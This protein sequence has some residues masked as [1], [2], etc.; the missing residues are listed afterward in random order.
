ATGATGATGPALYT[1]NFV[2]GN[3]TNFGNA[4]YIMTGSGLTPIATQP[5]LGVLLPI[6][7]STL[8]LSTAVTGIPPAPY[9]MEVFKIQPPSTTVT[10]TGLVCQANSSGASCTQT[11]TGT[12]AASAGDV[13]QVQLTGTT[14]FNSWSGAVYA[15]LTCQ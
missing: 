9:T 2:V 10:S 3:G 11:Q 7:C 4:T 8:T 15:T 1:A 13:L 14:A 12:Y 6:N 5:Y